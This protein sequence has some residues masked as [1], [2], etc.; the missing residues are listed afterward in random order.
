VSLSDVSELTRGDVLLVT[1]PF[2]DLSSSK[3]RPAILLTDTKKAKGLD[4]HFI[5]VGTELPPVGEM[6]IEVRF[7]SPD[8]RTMGLHITSYIRPTKVCTLDVSLVKRR[9]GY[10]PRSLLDRITA[11]IARVLGFQSQPPTSLATE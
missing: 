11:E 7:G 1:F 4:G 9:I 6:P 5:F 10:T 2:T 3:V 8:A